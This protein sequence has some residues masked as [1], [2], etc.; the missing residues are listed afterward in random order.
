MFKKYLRFN[1]VIIY[2]SVFFSL[3]F[4]SSSL[5]I[6]TEK[7]EESSPSSS[8]TRMKTRAK[9]WVSV[10]RWRCIADEKIDKLLLKPTMVKV[11]PFINCLRSRIKKLYPKQLVGFLNSTAASIVGG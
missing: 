11:N 3:F 1:F 6:A 7:R 8:F 9:D 10:T 5:T 4:A 2:V